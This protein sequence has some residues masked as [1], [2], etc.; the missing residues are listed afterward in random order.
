MISK[1][2]ERF[3]H[4]AQE[5]AEWSKDP[6]TKV[7]AIIADDRNRVIATGYNGFPRGIKDDER[8]DD[9]ETKY[10]IVIHA[11]IN[12]VL[13]AT[14][15]VVGCRI[16]T[17]PVAPC[18]NCAAVLIQAGI[19]LVVAPAMV[20]ERFQESIELGKALFRE[21]KVS[22]WLWENEKIWRAT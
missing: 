11:E 18:S 14:K 22:V 7:G 20:H 9:R 2:D 8:L 4:L 19:H 10:S 12:A 13:N 17:W 3:I 6:S 5:V 15:S 21:A 1:W 16:Y